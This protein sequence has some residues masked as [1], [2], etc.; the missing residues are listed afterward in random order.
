MYI[1]PNQVRGDHHSNM[2]MLQRGTAPAF[3]GPPF[4]LCGSGGL[5]SDRKL[6]FRKGAGI[7]H[8]L[9]RARQETDP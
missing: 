6:L 5:T 8:R 4:R 3:L 7:R 9:L 2:V 1:T